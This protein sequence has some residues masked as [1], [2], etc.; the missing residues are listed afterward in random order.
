M[1]FSNSYN[2]KILNIRNSI[3]VVQI[4]LFTF[5]QFYLTQPIVHT[6]N[7]TGPLFIFLLDYKINQV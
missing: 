3:I 1:T 4:I 7:S 5:L 2:L 6:I